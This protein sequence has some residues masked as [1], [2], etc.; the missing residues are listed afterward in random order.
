MP[1]IGSIISMQ[2]DY[3]QGIPESHQ[4]YWGMALRSD[5]P[6]MGRHH[7]IRWPG[8]YDGANALVCAGLNA[9]EAYEAGKTIEQGGANVTHLVLMHNDVVPEPYW[10]DALMT[11]MM[12]CG[13]DMLAVVTPIKDMEGKSSCAIDDDPYQ[14]LRRIMM[15]EIYDLPPTFSATDCGYPEGSLLLNHGLCVFDFTKPWWREVNEDGTL[16]LRFT[17]PDRIKRRPPAPGKELGTWE[18]QH[19]PSDWHIS[20]ELNK[21]GAKLMATRKI[22]CQH[23]GVVPFTNQFAWGDYKIDEAL[24]HKFG[25]VPIRNDAWCAERDK[26]E[27]DRMN[28]QGESNGEQSSSAATG[29]AA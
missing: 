6:L 20:R 10:L 18:A 28:N 21:R 4:A 5:S 29:E 23:F 17:S 26:A 8:S 9:L 15:T 25:R 24:A 2:L 12:L 7:Q 11:E 13:A 14:V 19:A 22:K 3:G 16:A 27:T 1:K